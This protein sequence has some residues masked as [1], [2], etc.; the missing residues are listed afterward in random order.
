MATIL[1]E[2]CI[3]NNH[4]HSEGQFTT[5]KNRH[6]NDASV[7]LKNTTPWK[8]VCLSYE[9]HQC[10][11]TS[12]LT[13]RIQICPKKGISPTFLFWGWDWDHQSYSRERSGFLGQAICLD[14]RFYQRSLSTFRNF[15]SIFLSEKIMELQDLTFDRG[16]LK[17][18]PRKPSLFKKK[19]NLG[20]PV[21][22]R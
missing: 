20:C 18:P 12:W 6:S 14:S 16:L 4:L 17:Q 11:H 22:L 9:N 1:C 2:K 13:W 8:L 10:F 19:C 21:C 3:S 5:W 7:C 15:I